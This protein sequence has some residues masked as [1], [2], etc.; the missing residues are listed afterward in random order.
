MP[1]LTVFWIV[2]PITGQAT[3][4][5]V[6]PIAPQIA[7]SATVASLPLS[8]NG[9]AAPNPA[10]TN[11]PHLS[12]DILCTAFP[13]GANDSATS[14]RNDPAL[15]A[16]LSTNRFLFCS[17]IPFTSSPNPA[18]PNVATSSRFPP[19]FATVSRLPA[20]KFNAPSQARLNNDRVSGASFLLSCIILTASIDEILSACIFKSAADSS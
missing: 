1:Y 9:C 17:V 10:P 11:A 19:Y 7:T 5:T 6:P 13:S 20:A 8:S 18:C 12:S 4:P 2:L 16:V 14:G 15:N 3:A